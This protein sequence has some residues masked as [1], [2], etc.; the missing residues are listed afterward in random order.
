MRHVGRHEDEVAG[1]G[2]RDELQS[3]PPSASVMAL[4]DVDDALQC[5]VVMYAGLGVRSDAD[6]PG[7]DLL[8]ADAR[9]VD[10]RLPEHARR[11][12]SVGVKLVALDVAHTVVL[13]AIISLGVLVV[14]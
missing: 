14:G 2:L 6:G 5:A 10:R 11:L 9:V 8:S 1:A 12:R 4:H 3:R 13:P 7:P